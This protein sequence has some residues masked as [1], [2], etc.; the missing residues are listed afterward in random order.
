MDSRK[1]ERILLLILVLLNVFLLAVVLTD[2]AQTRRSES[3]TAARLEARLQEDG[4][5]AADGALVIRTAPP[6]CTLSRDMAAE[7]RLMNQLIG[8]AQVLDQGGNIFFYSGSRGQAL[9]RGSGEIDALFQSSAVQMHTSAERTALRLLQRSGIHAVAAAGNDPDGDSAEFTCTLDG[10]PVY[11][12]VLRFSFVDGSLNMLT[13][14]RVFDSA[15][16]ET[17]AGLLDSVSVLIRFVELVR[18]EG[19]ICSRIDAVEPGYLQTVTRSGE[20]A[21][22]PVWRIETDAGAFVI[23]AES[24]KA[25]TRLP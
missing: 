21:L 20:A 14:T 5:T 10:F 7:E 22:A 17:D 3:E 24:G 6:K 16:K 19:Y 13:G 12:A 11:N 4:I 23:D 25:E 15:V 1:L 2:R 9:L 8:T 18:A